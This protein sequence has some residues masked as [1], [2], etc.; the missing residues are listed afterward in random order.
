MWPPNMPLLPTEITQESLEQ[1][2]NKWRNK[3]SY[4]SK[5]YPSESFLLCDT[6]EGAN[7]VT[8]R[9]P[10]YKSAGPLYTLR[11]R[12][13]G[14]AYERWVPQREHRRPFTG[15]YGLKISPDGVMQGWV[16]AI[17][18][19]NG[20][21]PVY[22]D[23]E[24]RQELRW[25]FPPR[26]VV[27]DVRYAR[28]CGTNQC[29]TDVFFD[30]FVV[31]ID[32]YQLQHLIRELDQYDAKLMDHVE[33]LIAEWAFQDPN[34]DQVAEQEFELAQAAMRWRLQRKLALC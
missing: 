3:E 33:D 1:W 26:V 15:E 22:Q 13:H 17:P 23:T 2:L 6:S 16:P 29:D 9:H 14:P 8:Y 18:G 24:L 25:I 21:P 20:F 27:M 11:V 30:F 31:P 5:L 10:T 28:G 12:L 7:Y 19:R 32:E 34:M 4:I